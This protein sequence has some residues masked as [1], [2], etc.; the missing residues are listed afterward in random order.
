MKRIVKIGIAV[1]AAIFVLG[2][3]VSC[4]NGTTKKTP[5]PGPGAKGTNAKLT[6]VKFGNE[7]ATL[8]TPGAKYSSAV[9]GAVKILQAN[10]NITAVAEDTKA[11]IQYAKVAEGADLDMADLFYDTTFD[12]VTGDNLAIEVTAEDGKTKLYYKIAVTLADVALNTL[13][14]GDFEVTVPGGGTSW[15]TAGE[16]FALFA[17]PVDQQPTGGLAIVAAAADTAAVIAYAKVTGDGAPTFGTDTS[18]TFADEDYLYV[19][20]TKGDNSAFYK[21]KINFMQSGTIKYGS[22]KIG[23]GADGSDI[24]VDGLPTTAGTAG[25][26]DPLWNDPTLEVYP[27]AKIYGADS[28]SYQGLIDGGLAPTVAS[29]K[30]YWDEEGL[31]VYVKVIDPDV[32]AVDAEHETDSFELFINEDLTFTGTGAQ[33]YSNG[34]SQYRVAS[35]GKRSG[36]GQSPTAMGALNKTT[37]WHTSDGYIVI[38]KAPWRLRNKFFSSTTY[39]NDWS[40]GFELQINCAPEAGNR[41]AVLVWNNVAHTNYQ[42]AQDYGIAKLV[43]GPATP[44]YPALPPTITTNPNSRI[45]GFGQQNVTLSVAASTIDGGNITYQWYKANDA[46]AAGTA[47]TG[48]TNA[49]YK[50]NAPNEET[51][52]YYYAVATNTLGTKTATSTSS[53]AVITVTDAPMVEQFTL[54]QNNPVYKFNLLDDFSNYKTITVQYYMVKAEFDKGIRSVRLMGNYKETDFSS[55]VNGYP[56]Y[57]FDTANAAYIYDDRGAT[58]IAGNATATPP[59][60][61]VGKAG[62]WFT[63]TYRL[64]G[65]TGDPANEN[66]PAQLIGDKPNPNGSFSSTN[67]PAANARGPL[68]FGVGIPGNENGAKTQ[69]IKN[70]TVVHATDAA[71]N[72]SVKADDFVGFVGYANA[73]SMMI[74]GR[75]FA[76]DPSAIVVP[77][78]EGPVPTLIGAPGDADGTI[79]LNADT[80]TVEV[81]NEKSGTNIGVWYPL[82]TMEHPIN[83]Y[84]TVKIYITANIIDVTGGNQITAKSGKTFASDFVASGQ[85]LG[86]A[87][88]EQTFTLTLTNADRLKL[89]GVDAIAFQVNSWAS[90]AGNKKMY[91]DFLCTKIEVSDHQGA[92]VP[93]ELPSVTPETFTVALIQD[94]VVTSTS[95]NG[96]PMATGV[97]DGSQ[98]VFTFPA[99]DRTIAAINL[100]PEQNAKIVAARAGEGRIKIKIT[101]TSTADIKINYWIGNTERS[102]QWN[103]TSGLGETA[104]NTGNSGASISGFESIQTFDSS[105]TTNN[106]Q[107]T[108]FVI[109]SQQALAS[110]ITITEIEIS[111]LAKE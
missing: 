40:F 45:V 50:F 3:A 70:I 101:G 111:I 28:G 66:K 109:R 59:V 27:I 29:A 2:L 100:T 99:T 69:L 6:S 78:P 107:P 36:E 77:V 79:A 63:A 72:V 9:A 16:G 105:A 71:K 102:N 83:E 44:A 90:S 58:Y 34:G 53:R 85:Y 57:G 12:F 26:I 68:L 104:F 65:T 21:I 48:E 19:K 37:A 39:R 17:Y 81:R 86:L 110:V 47:I 64:N 73:G 32:S 46:S 56:H 5:A 106:A 23:Y 55:V 30:A 87:Q 7:S 88:G 4:D 1:L 42:N 75:D 11:T 10:A 96:N 84:G 80:K 38:M 62:E 31:S 61:G 33:K 67:M 91:F 54:A 13:K 25:Y 89:S 76:P 52:L 108:A 41:Y 20:V 93:P 51:K 35:A 92:P 24:G 74:S 22:P 97:A 8:G 14:I 15:Q 95:I 103:I 43:N 18:F 82:P 49:T 94:A 60:V 98:V